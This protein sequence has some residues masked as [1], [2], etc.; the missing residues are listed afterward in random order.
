VCELQYGALVAILFDAFD[1]GFEDVMARK[2]YVSNLALDA[3]ALPP[4]RRSLAFMCGY[5]TPFAH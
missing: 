5:F 1:F 3:L 2:R 4:G